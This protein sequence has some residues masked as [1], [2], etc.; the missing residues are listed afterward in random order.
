MFDI[1]FYIPA[2][3]IV[4]SAMVIAFSNDMRRILMF[5][6]AMVFTFASILILLKAQLLALGLLAVSGIA[7]ML[8]SSDSNKQ[9]AL[10]GDAVSRKFK[11][12]LFPVLALS[13]ATAIITNLSAS[14]RWITIND[15]SD[16]YSIVFTIYLPIIFLVL[17]LAS[18]V[19]R[20]IT[21]SFRK[22]SQT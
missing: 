5:S 8:V 4:F 12:M 2:L 11:L 3:L 9:V 19:I 15:N 1:L 7:V 10:P 20:L 18:V 21:G 17:L 14:T 22:E 6:A 16:D 13:A